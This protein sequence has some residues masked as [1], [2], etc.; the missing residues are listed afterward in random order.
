MSGRP[1][2]V[3]I[4]CV[5]N[6]LVAADAAG[7]QVH[8]RLAG[9]PLPPGVE[10]VDGGLQGLDLLIID[11]LRYSPHPNHFNIEGALQ[12][13]QALRPRRTLFTH[14]THEVH[15]RDGTRLPPGVEF[16]YDGMTIELP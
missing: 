14:L 11:A 10:L 2:A 13:V 5:G 16:A 12:M 7:P 3:R 9:R 1:A 15:H 8:D 4:I 6:R